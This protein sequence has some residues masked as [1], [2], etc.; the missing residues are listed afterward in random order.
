M[1]QRTSDD[2]I[3]LVALVALLVQLADEAGDILREVE[4]R[5]DM[6]VVDKGGE[7][8]VD[9]TYEPDSQ[10]AA[11]REVRPRVCS[12]RHAQP[13]PPSLLNSTTV[14]GRKERK[15]GALGTL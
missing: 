11:D 7:V 8:T 15:M 9:G 10:T 3:D 6:G 14:D 1:G 4:A 5:P 2:R 12:V 13:A